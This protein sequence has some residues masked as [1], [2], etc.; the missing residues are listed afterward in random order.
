MKTDYRLRMTIDYE[1]TLEHYPPEVDT[2]QKALQFDLDSVI[3]GE[4]GLDDWLDTVDDVIY[5][6]VEVEVVE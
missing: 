2:K 4:L 3:S 6:V 1:P 5:E